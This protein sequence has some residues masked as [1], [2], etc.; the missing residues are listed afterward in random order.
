MSLAVFLT[1]VVASYLSI[2][3]WKV[4]QITPDISPAVVAELNLTAGFLFG[5]MIYI[6]NKVYI[7][8]AGWFTQRENHKF[9]TDHDNALIT[10]LFIFQFFNSYSAVFAA[11]I[12]ESLDDVVCQICSIVLTKQFWDWFLDYLVPYLWLSYK[13]RRLHKNRKKDGDAASPQM[14]EKDAVWVADNYL[15]PQRDRVLHNKYSE[16]VIQFGFI[17]QFS[18][19]F[20]FLALLAIVFN[21]LTLKMDIAKVLYFQRRRVSSGTRGVGRWLV[22][23]HV[24]GITSTVVNLLILNGVSSSLT[25]FAV[26]SKSTHFC[27]HFVLK[28]LNAKINATMIRLSNGTTAHSGMAQVMLDVGK[29]MC[30]NTTFLIF[31]LFGLEHLFLLCTMSLAFLYS[32][33][34][35]WVRQK[36]DQEQ[37]LEVIVD[38]S[39]EK[40]LSKFARMRMAVNA[41]R[42]VL[43]A[44]NRRN[45]L[46]FPKKER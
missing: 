18:A 28:N 41:T 13:K 7:K 20:P 24:V 3:A 16:I 22:I 17:T 9:H 26:K 46:V 29:E 11:L 32:N 12:T 37:H 4:A 40:K 36:V 14:K 1:G 38:Q 33:E 2:N 5:T 25:D 42:G 8:A 31:F 35:T 39:N 10:K 43:R 21:V 19:I 30:G 34:P 23:M 45:R 27:S 6:L 15:L 44:K